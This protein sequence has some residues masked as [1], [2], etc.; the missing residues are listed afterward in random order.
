MVVPSVS[1]VSRFPFGIAL[2]LVGLPLSASPLR[3]PR[4]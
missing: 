4:E 3:G 1:A 2:V